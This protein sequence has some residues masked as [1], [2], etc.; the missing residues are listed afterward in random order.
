[1]PKYETKTYKDVLYFKY[2]EMAE[3][4]E[5]AKQQAEEVRRVLRQPGINKFLNDNSNIHAVA[6]PEVNEVWGEL[7][8]WVSDNIEKNATV[9]PNVTLKMQLNRLSKKA[10]TYERVRA[11]TTLE[12]A[13]QFMDVPEMKI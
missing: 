8:S 13:L 3:S 12:D 11:F 2:N 5:E 9:A 6:K 10:G 7:M 4:A 1:M